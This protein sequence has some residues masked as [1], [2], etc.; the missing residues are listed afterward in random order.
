MFKLKENGQKDEQW[1]TKHYT[2]DRVTW[3]PLKTGGEIMCS[4]RISSTCSTSGTL[5]CMC[6]IFSKINIVAEVID[7]TKF[8]F[9]NIRNV[10]MYIFLESN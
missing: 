6:V 7:V 5:N 10:Q 8:H 2:K 1:S 9:I 4:R 3:T